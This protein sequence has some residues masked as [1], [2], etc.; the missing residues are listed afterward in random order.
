MSSNVYHHTTGSS[1]PAQNKETGMINGD[2]P[3]TINGNNNVNSNTTTTTKTTCGSEMPMSHEEHQVAQAAARFRYGPPA[4][5]NNNNNHGGQLLLPAFSGQLQPGV[6][7]RVKAQAQHK[8][9]L[10]SVYVIFKQ[11]GF[12]N[13]IL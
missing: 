13:R 11:E 2:G 12:W 8:F 4:H 6:H 1:L 9:A 5:N 10:Y 7:T 3:N